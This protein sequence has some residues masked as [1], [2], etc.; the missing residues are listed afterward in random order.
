LNLAKGFVIDPP[1]LVTRSLHNVLSTLPTSFTQTKIISISANGLSK[2]S[3][4]ALPLLLK[5]LFRY[6]LTV[7]HQDKLGTERIASYCAGLEW[8]EQDGEV[9]DDVMGANWKQDLPRESGLSGRIVVVRPAL[10]TDGECVA[11]KE[12]QKGYRV[13]DADLPGSWTI[14]RRDVA[15]FLVEG[16]LKNWDE[17]KDKHI[18]IAY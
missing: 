4:K 6:F 11:D 9:G 3:H 15:H 1:N 7:P 18:S 5:P 14:S 13:S 17:Y 10:L 16:V 12:Q 8:D 2:S